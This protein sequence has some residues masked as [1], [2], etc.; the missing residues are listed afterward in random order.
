MEKEDDLNEL[1]SYLLNEGE[2]GRTILQKHG[3]SRQTKLPQKSFIGKNIKGVFAQKINI[4]DA[5]N[6][7]LENKYMKVFEDLIN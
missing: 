4:E 3:V 7:E 5:L 1:R 2:R 6:E